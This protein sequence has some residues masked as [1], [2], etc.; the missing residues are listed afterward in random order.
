MM[1]EEMMNQDEF[2]Q[3]KINFETGQIRWQEL[4][5]FFASGTA[6]A[7]DASLNLT[8]VGRVIAQDNAAQLKQWMDTGLVDNVTDQQA[9]AWYDADARVWAVVIKPWV[10]VQVLKR[11]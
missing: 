9:Q 1:N 11:S 2:L 4:Q 7:V 3:T 6:I 10:L 5:R 8:E